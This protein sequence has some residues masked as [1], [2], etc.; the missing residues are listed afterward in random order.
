MEYV[1][2]QGDLVWMDFDPQ[3]GH[4]QAGRRPAIVLSPAAYNKRTGLMLCC[5]MTTKAKGNPWEVPV[6]AHRGGVVL[7]D[8]VKSADWTARSIEK[9][10]TATKLELSQVRK[11]A[12]ALIG[13]P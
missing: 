11:F 13:Q 1:P 4:E 12:R 7:S 8:Q 6:T 2:D 9:L 3:A 10:G 5:P